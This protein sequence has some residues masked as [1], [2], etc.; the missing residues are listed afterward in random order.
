MNSLCLCQIFTTDIILPTRHE[1]ALEEDVLEIFD[2]L[3]DVSFII[4]F[5]LMF[6]MN[7]VHRNNNVSLILMIQNI[8]RNIGL[9]K[10]YQSFIMWNWIVII[11]TICMNMI[12]NALYYVTFDYNCV[13]EIILDGLTDFFIMATDINVVIATRII[14]LLRKYLEEWIEDALAMDGEREDGDQCLKL[15]E[16]YENIL[17]SFDLF[18]KIFQASVSS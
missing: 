10:G 11:S 9:S 6:I 5:T 3:Y 13:R 17:K 1:T 12:I 14:I 4:G 7:V 2:L 16:I 15:L 8:H 18:K